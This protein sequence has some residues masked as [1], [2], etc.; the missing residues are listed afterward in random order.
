MPGQK[1]AQS[2]VEYHE[3][4]FKVRICSID[5]LDEVRIRHYG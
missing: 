5:K 1:D 4:G 3:G 2:M